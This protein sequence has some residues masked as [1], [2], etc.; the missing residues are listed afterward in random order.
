[1]GDVRIIR[2]DQSAEWMEVLKNTTRHDFYHL[3]E[4]HALAQDCGEGRPYLFVYTQENYTI[5]LPLLL[6]PLNDVASL[7]QIG[8]GWKDASSVYGYAGPVVS[9]AAMPQSLL[10]D[11]GLALR[12]T[13]Q[14]LQ[15]LTVFSR[16]HPLIA[17]SEILSGL[18]EFRS[19]GQTVSIDLTIPADVQRAK[20]RKA[21]KEGINRLKRWGAV[22]SPDY[23]KHHLNEFIDIY[24]ETMCRVN[25][26]KSYFFS[27]D[28]FEH[29]IHDFTSNIHLFL[30]T[31]NERF[32]CGGLFMVYNGVIQYHLG[33][34]LNEFVRFAPMK[35]LIDTVRLWGIEQN[36][37]MFHLGGGLGGQEDSLFHFKSG[38]SDRRHD[39][40]TWRWVLFPD[41]Y[42]EVSATKQ[43]WNQR[44]GL[45]TEFLDY[46]P[47]YRCPTAV[48]ESYG[49]VVIP[50][51]VSR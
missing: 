18:G 34:T 47:A 8:N 6:R 30:I 17:Q 45:E 37:H 49:H 2:P 20:Y 5:A 36:L 21:H 7:E 40:V 22:C 50:A 9:H 31:M 25:A 15:V 43:A 11:F 29:L 12:T 13:L 24:Y 3:P 51:V 42:D 26:S 46:F 41:V 35:L 19:T 4:Y 14:E 32:V 39:F 10:L 27:H 48:S 16:L 33:G 44:H 38:F 23:D 1:M 28:Y